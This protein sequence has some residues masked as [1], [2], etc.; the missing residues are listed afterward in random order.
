MIGGDFHRPPD[1]ALPAAYKSPVQ[2]SLFIGPRA[3]AVSRCVRQ[4]QVI[5][6]GCEQEL[7]GTLTTGGGVVSGA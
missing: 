5:G 2:Q 3:P 6:R 4:T 1:K 7:G